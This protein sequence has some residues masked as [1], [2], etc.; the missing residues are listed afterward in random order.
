MHRRLLMN[1]MRRWYTNDLLMPLLAGGVA[2]LA[3]RLVIPAP[4]GDIATFI[5]LA[6]ALVCILL[7]ASL[8]A[9]LV[10]SDLSAHLRLL[11]GRSS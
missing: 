2:A 3:L 7:S 11:L 8:G 1:E 9:S 10:R 4:A 5:F 6:L